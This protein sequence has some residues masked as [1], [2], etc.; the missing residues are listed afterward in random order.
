MNNKILSLTI[1]LFSTCLLANE[2]NSTIQLKSLEQAF[3]KKQYHEIISQIEAKKS[4]SFEESLFLTQSLYRIREFDDAEEIISYLLKNNA[5]HAKT[6]YVY[7]SVMAAQAQSSIFS[8][9]N[10]AGKALDGFK[11]AVDI[12]PNNLNY[13]SALMQFYINAPSI[14]G[15]D[16]EQGLLLVDKINALD[17]KEGFYA[18]FSYYMQ[19]D[20]DTALKKII[21]EG[22]KQF[23][24]DIA[25]HTTI[26][27]AYWDDEKLT[28]AQEFFIKASKLPLQKNAKTN[29]IEQYEIDNHLESLYYTGRIANETKEHLDIGIKA[30]NDYIEQVNNPKDERYQWAHFRL[31]Q[32]YKF[33]QQ[34]DEAETLFKWAYNNATDKKLKKKAKK[35]L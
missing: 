19:D 18:K 2:P 10:Y 35:Q 22:Q 13:L 8:A 14:A 9:L 21:A 17:K 7:A 34:Q 3:E 27:H 29:K 11:K 23:P 31:A 1:L 33:N 25:V 30:L 32:L 26:G 16:M 6:N 15:G 12:E 24:K 4:P 28:K 20:N 5:E